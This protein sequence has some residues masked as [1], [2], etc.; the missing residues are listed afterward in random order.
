MEE[1]AFKLSSEAMQDFDS[2]RWLAVEGRCGGEQW[3]SMSKDTETGRSR[4]CCGGEERL[5]GYFL[6]H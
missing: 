6:I 5:K 2:W 4:T 1:K 3:N